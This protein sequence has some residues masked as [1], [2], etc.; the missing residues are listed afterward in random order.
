MK[1][2]DIAEYYFFCLGFI[3]LGLIVVASL[4]NLLVIRIVAFYSQERLLEKLRAEEAASQAV[5][6]KGDVICANNTT[7]RRSWAVSEPANNPK[8]GI[9]SSQASVCSC[10][11]FETFD[12]W[13]KT[14]S[15]RMKRK[16]QQCSASSPSVAMVFSVRRSS[17]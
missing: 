15:N 12:D 11:C 8:Q 17:V 5:F 14:R 13:R 6:L 16:K 3:F 7:R 9:Y 10:T 1:F 2:I 4:M